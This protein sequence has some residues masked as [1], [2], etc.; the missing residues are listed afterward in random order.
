MESRAE[1]QLNWAPGPDVASSTDEYALR[2]R[3]GIGRWQLGVQNRLLLDLLNPWQG[4]RVL[5][6]GGGHG[7]YTDDL[8]EA[9]FDLTVHGSAP[10]TARRIQRQI[11]AGSCRFM[12]GDMLNLP[13]ADQEFDCVVSVRQLAHVEDPEK[14]LGE[15]CRVARHAVVVDYPPKSGFNVM[16]K[17][18]FPLKSLLE[19]KS[20]RPYTVFWEPELAAMIS[21]QG[22][23]VTGHEAQFGLP[24][25]VHRVVRWV[26]LI[27]LL[28]AICKRVGLTRR[29][30]GPV[31]L[32]A[33]R[34]VRTE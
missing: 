8:I 6:V 10:E 28:E 32:R 17:L 18:L 24:M 2:F 12:V 30:G 15:L 20:T 11:E 7:Q 5:D 27:R 21:G 19:K 3:G 25:V 4:G 33:E 29:I 13:F 23:E 34:R 1:E 26:R 9:G 22:F 31:L 14:F 16:S